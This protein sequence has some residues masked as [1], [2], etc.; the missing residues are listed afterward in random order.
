MTAPFAPPPSRA[1]IAVA[2]ALLA[3]AIVLPFARRDDWTGGVAFVT[4]VA[5]NAVIGGLMVWRL[6][7]RWREPPD[8]E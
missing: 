1:I 6:I 2:A 4:L 3:V 5:A 7:C 8:S